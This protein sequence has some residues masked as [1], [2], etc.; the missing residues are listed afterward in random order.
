MRRLFIACVATAF[1]GPS[2]A[3]A[4]TRAYDIVIQNGRVIDPESGLDADRSVG[5]RGA[6]IA[7]VSR[8]PLQGRQVI[9]ARGLVVAPG[10]I[11]LHVHG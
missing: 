6:T 11:D 5:I 8:I 2:L 1:L 3:Y 10:F 7:A 4:Q 9:D